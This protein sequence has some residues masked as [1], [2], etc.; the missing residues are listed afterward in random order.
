MTARYEAGLLHG[1]PVFWGEASG[2]QAFGMLMFRV[3]HS[4]EHLLRRGISHL[5][6]HLTLHGLDHRRDSFNGSVDLLCTAFVCSGTSEEVE[7]FISKCI[8]SLHSL[9]FQR[10][11]KEAQVLRAEATR[12]SRSVLSSAL[13]LRFGPVGPGAFDYEE[14]FLNQPQ[15][16]LIEDWRKRFFTRGNAAV[17][18]SFAPTSSMNLDRLPPG[19]PMR[20]AV[21]YP[22]QIT[23]PA[24]HVTGPGGI[25][26][27]FLLDTSYLSSATMAI[28]AEVLHRHLRDDLGL[29]YNVSVASARLSADVVHHVLSADCQP[30]DAREVHERMR[31]EMSRLLYHG[32]PQ[33]D[34]DEFRA[35]VQRRQEQKGAGFGLAQYAAQEWLLGCGVV[36]PA[37]L[38]RELQQLT[39]QLVRE[40]LGFAVDG[41]LWVVPRGVEF[42]DRRPT[43]IP[44]YS[45]T[46]IQ[47][48]VYSRVPGEGEASTMVV[49]HHG[50]SLVLSEDKFVTVEFSRLAACKK[51]A[52]GARTLFGLDGFTLF[53]DP[54]QWVHGAQLVEHID[55][56]VPPMLVITSPDA[57]R[58]S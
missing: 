19:E 57:A 56:C 49:G 45:S 37:E 17:V 23:Y 6:E 44:G 15:Q 47:G 22:V 55:R 35:T 34:L 52:D 58:V 50:I 36:D 11:A 10:V 30:R 3:G 51:W 12:R 4:D 24:W 48:Q 42:T 39:T 38:D 40:R 8:D 9:P 7:Q 29:S 25:G 18:L 41:A 28:L 33:K 13:Q 21:P 14:L 27:S 5:I 2:D 26:V 53:V 46:L 20:N 43:W 16:H 54:T 1:V 31:T 32:I